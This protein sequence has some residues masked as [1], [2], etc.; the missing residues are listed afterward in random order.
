MNRE[1]TKSGVDFAEPRSVPP[2]LAKKVEMSDKAL[3]DRLT[4]WDLLLF[5]LFW[6][7]PT[8]FHPWWAALTCW[9]VCIFL[10]LWMHKRIEEKR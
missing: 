10:W 9:G 1:E 5:L 3:I 4:V 6:I 7:F 8:P 2:A